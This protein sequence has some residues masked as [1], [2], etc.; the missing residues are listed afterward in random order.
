MGW[1]IASTERSGRQDMQYLPLLYGRFASRPPPQGC[2]CQWLLVRRRPSLY[3]GPFE[4]RAIHD[5]SLCPSSI[6]CKANDV[7]SS[8]NIF[9]SIVGA[10]TPLQQRSVAK[11]YAARPTAIQAALAWLIINN[12]LYANIITDDA[13]TADRCNQANNDVTEKMEEDESMEEALQDIGNRH[14]QPPSANVPIAIRS[15]RH[16]PW[17]PRT[18]CVVSL[19][20][21]TFSLWPWWA[22][23]KAV[24]PSGVAI[25]PEEVFAT[26]FRC[27]P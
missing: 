24:S 11:C 26:L 22:R 6:C 2:Y 18:Q 4:D 20:P 15:L 19:F 27:F 5:R 13:T 23:G 12:A 16:L 25:L 21:H 3:A 10:L 9:V 8:G 1:G 17:R 7:G 14:H